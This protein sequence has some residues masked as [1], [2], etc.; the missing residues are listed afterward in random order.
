VNLNSKLLVPAVF[1]EIARLTDAGQIAERKAMMLKSSAF[2]A[3]L[4]LGLILV[5]AVFGRPLIAG[6]AGPAFTGAYATMLWLAFAGGVG[7][8]SFTLEPFLLAHGDTRSVVQANALALVVHVTLLS[9]LLPRIGLVGA[10]IAA[11]AQA[12]AQTLLLSGFILRKHTAR[13]RSARGD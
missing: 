12:V 11:V 13:T 7:A 9:L 1:P 8:A 10:G 6:I 2:I 5:L 3:T 4:A